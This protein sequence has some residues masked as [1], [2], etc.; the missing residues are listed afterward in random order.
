MRGKLVFNDL[1]RAHMALR[2]DD[3]MHSGVGGKGGMFY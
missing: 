1:A 3:G 2:S